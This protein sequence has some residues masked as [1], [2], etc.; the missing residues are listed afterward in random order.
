[1][2]FTNNKGRVIGTSLSPNCISLIGNKEIRIKISLAEEYPTSTFFWTNSF[3]E[4]KQTLMT[5]VIDQGVEEGGDYVFK[6]E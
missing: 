4:K 2:I 1:M 5:V 6:L 3:G